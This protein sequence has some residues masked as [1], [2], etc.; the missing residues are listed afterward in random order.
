MALIYIVEDDESIGALVRATLGAIGHEG[1]VLPNAQALFEAAAAQLPGLLILD[2]MLPGQDG[3]DI[4]SRWRDG[5]DT[6]EIPVIMLSALSGELDKVR[7]LEMGA[8]DY[9]TKPFGV[10]EMQARVKAALR[11]R[12]AEAEDAF[13]LGDLQVDYRR[14]KAFIAGAELRLTPM[15]MRLLE[16]LCRNAPN[17]VSRDTLIERVWDREFEG[18]TTRT[19]DYH[20]RALRKKLGDTAEDARYIET[21]RGFGYR[22][23]GQ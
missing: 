10:L 22:M 9:I 18:E 21:V 11:R 8:E 15:E 14:K 1:R 6:R 4:L 5:A 19:V 2:I 13:K 7:A 3:F 17:V 20:V 23:R 12:R 16:Y